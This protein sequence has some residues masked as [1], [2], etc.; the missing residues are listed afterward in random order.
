MSCY[1]DYYVGFGIKFDNDLFAAKRLL[2]NSELS[3]IENINDNYNLFYENFNKEILKSCF[4]V[5]SNIDSDNTNYT[6]VGI[7][8]KYF[9]DNNPEF[10]I[11]EMKLST[12]HKFNVVYNPIDMIKLIEI[13][14]IEEIY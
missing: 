7:P 13:E 3:N 5:R 2:S 11:N 1:I 12:M 9:I 8:L 10:S 14:Y 4:R 6:I